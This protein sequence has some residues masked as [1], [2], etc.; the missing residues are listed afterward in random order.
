MATADPNPEGRP[1]GLYA[2]PQE[3]LKAVVADYQ[4]WTGRLTD[5]SAQMSYGII[6][7][8]WI[9]FGSVSVILSSIWAKLSL[10]SVMLS[11]ATSVVGTWLL[12]EGHRRRG[13]YGDCD[14]KRWKQEFTQFANK[15]NPWPFTRFIECTA[16]WSRNLKAGF[17]LLGAAFLIVAA[18][19]K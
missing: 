15:K 5:A 14:P 12:C 10:L 7:A 13:E 1:K 11:L 8:N 9:V 4:Y 3:A 2:D 6:A 16:S 18:I 19:V 17:V